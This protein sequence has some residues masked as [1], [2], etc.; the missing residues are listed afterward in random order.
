MCFNRNTTSKFFVGISFKGRKFIIRVEYFDAKN[1]FSHLFLLILKHIPK[2]V[3]YLSTP[4][5][6]ALKIRYWRT[7]LNSKYTKYNAFLSRMVRQNNVDGRMQN[8]N[9]Y[10]NQVGLVVI[11]SYVNQN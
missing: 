7:F 6:K 2:V 3:Q 4:I 1:I 8:R 10:V 5:K 11:L 9:F